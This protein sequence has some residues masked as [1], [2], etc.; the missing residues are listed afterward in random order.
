MLYLF[1]DKIRLAVK[2]ELYKDYKTLL[3]EKL[4]DYIKGVNIRY[5]IV[6]EAG[7]DHSKEFVAAVLVDGNELGRGIGKSKK[8]S[9][10][11]AAADAL[12]KGDI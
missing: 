3:Q 12:M 6:N 7:P 2:G 8:E 1:A 5:Q 11:A 9:E 10:Q 4:Q